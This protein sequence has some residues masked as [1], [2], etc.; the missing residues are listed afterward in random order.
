MGIFFKTANARLKDGRLT[1]SAPHA[2]PPVVWNG[3]LSE[4][5]AASFNL[6]HIEGGTALIY[7]VPGA[8][9]KETIAWFENRASARQ[10]LEALT[11]AMARPERRRF[12]GIAV[13]FAAFLGGIASVALVFW[14]S[15]AL[16]ILPIFTQVSQNLQQDLMAGQGQPGAADAQN[17]GTVQQGRNPGPQ[18]EPQSSNRPGLPQDADEVLRQRR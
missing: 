8:K 12:S 14:M 11:R 9:K 7:T 3:D 18:A 10:A 2:E 16:I 13:Y 6:E 4:M 15:F 17:P 5:R 1:V